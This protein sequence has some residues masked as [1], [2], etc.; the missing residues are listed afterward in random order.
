MSHYKWTMAVFLLMSLLNPVEGEEFEFRYSGIDEVGRAYS[1]TYQYT[2]TTGTLSDLKVNYNNRFNFIPLSDGGPIIQLG[3]GVFHPESPGLKRTLLGTI[4]RGKSIIAKFQWA[5]EKGKFRFSTQLGLEGNRLKIT[6]TSLYPL[7]TGFSLG[8]CEGAKK[9]DIIRLPFMH[10]PEF[11]GGKFFGNILMVN[12]E[13]F[14]FAYFD[15][16]LSNA[17]FRK[18]LFERG[19][20]PKWTEIAYYEPKT[21]GMRNNLSETIWL[22]ISPKIEEVF[23]EIPNPPSR[24]LRE[25]KRRAWLDLW[26]GN[27]EHLSNQIS[28][29]YEA[30]MRDLFVT[31]NVWAHGGFDRFLP[32]VFPA[33]KGL[34]GDEKLRR[35]VEK[36]K[37]YGYRIGL[38]DQYWLI[39][40]QSPDYKEKHL[41]LK[42]NGKPLISHYE[43][44]PRQSWI[45]KA[46]HIPRFAQQRNTL[47]IKRHYAPNA[48]FI[49]SLFAMPSWTWSPDLID[50]DASVPAASMYRTRAKHFRDYIQHARGMLGPYLGE[51]LIS[52]PWAGIVDGVVAHSQNLGNHPN[53]FPPLIADFTL[54]RIHEK[55][56]NYGIGY[57]GRALPAELCLDSNNDG[58]FDGISDTGMYALIAYSI[59]FGHG[60][61]LDDWD[62]HGAGV[63][64]SFEQVKTIY[65]MMRPLQEKYIGVRVKKIEYGHE[66][67]SLLSLSE[68]VRQHATGETSF[69]NLYKSDHYRQIYVRYQNGLELF[70]NC[71]PNRNWE[72]T[73]RGK[74]YQLPT[75]GWVASDGRFLTY[76]A[77]VDGRRVD[78]VSSSG[79]NR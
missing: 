48:G 71:H 75:Y 64:P 6:F 14:S 69:E 41:S 45:L 18:S 12:Q 51:G 1:I 79:H 34:G 46:S 7:A 60:A 44:T 5:N 33:D 2:P 30:G 11:Q 9:T 29:C 52:W 67:G 15:W 39:M 25:L 74:R 37:S 26:N 73:L 72:V 49:D 36:A 77:L 24:F 78:Y 63:S 22:T 42:A 58:R 59:A 53:P 43:G 61:Y 21:N 32:T 35:L 19:E 68:C 17:T 66:D 76:S 50:H 16:N 55:M 13:C 23:P 4:K 28:R 31:L 3:K 27:F 47:G 57:A 65:K 56:V 8:R 62:T 40:E 70:V 54:R 38:R 10:L 20:E